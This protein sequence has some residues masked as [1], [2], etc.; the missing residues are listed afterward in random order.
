[1]NESNRIIA[2]SIIVESIES[3]GQNVRWTVLRVEFSFEVHA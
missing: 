3:V 1:M 2:V